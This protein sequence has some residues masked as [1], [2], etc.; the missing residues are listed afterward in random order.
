VETFTATAA[1]LLVGVVEDE[2]AAELVLLEGHFCAD[3]GHDGLAVDDHLDASFLDHL[4][5]LLYVLVA[6]VVHAVGQT[7][8]SLLGQTDL[9]AHLGHQNVTNSLS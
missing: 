7:R 4:V 6:D 2:L 5:E 1:S 9:H 8:A 3:E